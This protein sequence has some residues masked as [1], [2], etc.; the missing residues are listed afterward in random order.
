MHK[1]IKLRIYPN[2]EQIQI[3]EKTLGTL[4]FLYNK[5]LEYNSKLYQAYNDGLVDKGFMGRMKFYKHIYPK[6]KKE[7]TWIPECSDKCLPQAD[8]KATPVHDSC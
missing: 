4:R 2:E 1:V 5:Y 6:L 3:I 7:Y 8:R